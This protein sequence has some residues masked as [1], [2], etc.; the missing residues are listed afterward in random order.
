MVYVVGSNH[1]CTVVDT[2]VKT[3][4]D[5]FDFLNISNILMEGFEFISMIFWLLRQKNCHLK[6]L[7]L[8]FLTESAILCSEKGHILRAPIR[9]H[10]N[11]H[12]FDLHFIV[13]QYLYFNICRNCLSHLVGTW[14][15]YGLKI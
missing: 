4:I 13:T 12:N 1:R 3:K 2:R 7:I 9:V 15:K 6:K 8:Q 10:T 11:A 14:S 5:F